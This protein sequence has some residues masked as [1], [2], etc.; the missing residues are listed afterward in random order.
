M[1]DTK[2]RLNFKIEKDERYWEQRARLSWL[3]LGDRNT[4]FF[5]SQA[6]QRK[7]KNL[8][9]KLQNDSGW[10]TENLQEME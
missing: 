2:I 5:H 9:N 4:A 10:E 3:K 1:I 7:R 8:I 6:T